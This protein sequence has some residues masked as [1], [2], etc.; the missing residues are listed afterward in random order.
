MGEFIPSKKNKL[1][2]E[3]YQKCGFKKFQN[4]DKTHVWEFDLKYEFPFP[5]FIKF[6]IN[7]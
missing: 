6:K 3:F 5:D 1:A 2:E 7:R 4:K